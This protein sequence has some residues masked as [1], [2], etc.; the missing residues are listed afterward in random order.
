MDDVSGVVVDPILLRSPFGEQTVLFVKV[1]SDSLRILASAEGDWL[2]VLL[3]VDWLQFR[4]EAAQYYQSLAELN[5]EAARVRGEAGYLD[6]P[7]QETLEQATLRLLGERPTGGNTA[8]PI[9]HPTPR[10]PASTPNIQP[11][12]L[13]PGVVPIRIAGKAPKCFFA[14]LKA[15]VGVQAMGQD[16]NA[17]GVFH[18]LQISSEFAHACG[19][20]QPDPSGRYRQS[21]VPSLRKLEQF[22]QIMSARG[23]WAGIRRHTVRDNIAQGKVHIKG[24]DLAQD[25]TH[26]IAFSALD[27]ADV[28][29]EA[30]KAPKNSPSEEVPEA[31][32]EPRVS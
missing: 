31:T 7:D 27:V 5:A 19:F 1:R 15:F 21:D 16:A 10:P 28:P 11:D 26:Y 22:D 4:Q 3:G 30:T 25:T 14:L 8:A 24:Q 32:E 12:L 29:E 2:R 13:E 9:L 17:E 18:H 20:T 6:E 23:I